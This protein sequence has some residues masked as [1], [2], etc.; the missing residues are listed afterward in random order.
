MNDNI[1]K[2]R[3]KGIINVPKNKLT[4]D[5]LQVIIEDY[6]VTQSEAY[7]ILQMTIK[8]ANNLTTVD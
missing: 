8:Y 7:S 5:F 4:D 6:H 1:F 3:N 2:A